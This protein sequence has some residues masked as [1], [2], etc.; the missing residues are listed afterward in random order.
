MSRWDDQGAVLRG[1][2]GAVRAGM[3]C[4]GLAYLSHPVHR[5]VT[6]T[7]DRP[8]ELSAESPEDR[9]S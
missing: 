9:S 8:A 2:K 6:G 5:S 1:P 4:S 3:F 7:R